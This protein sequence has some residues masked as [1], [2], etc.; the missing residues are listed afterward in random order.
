MISMIFASTHVYLVL[1][2]VEWSGL[3]TK[4]TRLANSSLLVS[5]S[6]LPLQLIN[7]ALAAANI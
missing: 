3:I 5:L 1:A 2:A 4:R 7:S 6:V